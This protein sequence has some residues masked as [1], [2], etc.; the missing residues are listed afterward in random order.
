MAESYELE[1]KIAELAVQKAVIVTKKVL[2][3]VEKGDLTKGDRTLMSLTDFAAQALLVAAIHH[4]FPGDIIV[5]KEETTVLRNNRKMADQVWE[6]VSST[7][8]EDRE[9]EKLLPSPTSLDDMLHFIDLGGALY[10]GPKGRVWMTNPVDGTKGYLT[11]SQ[12][13]V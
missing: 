11:G 3:Y 9:C 7:H 10:S 1:Q 13:V 5:G 2:D 6:L 8:L 12:Y 4:N